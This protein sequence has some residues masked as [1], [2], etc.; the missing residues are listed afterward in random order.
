MAKK[1]YNIYRGELKTAGKTPTKREALIMKA[2]ENFGKMNSEIWRIRSFERRT[3]EKAN[4]LE[5]ELKAFGRM[6]GAKNITQFRAGTLTKLNMNQL[7]DIVARQERYLKHA[8][9]TGEGYERAY[10]Q[11]TKT[12]MEAYGFTEKQATDIQKLMSSTRVNDAIKNKLLDS[13]QVMRTVK[14]GNSV[15]NVVKFATDF[16]SAPESL[17]D[18]ISSLKG[19]EVSRIIQIT[20]SDGVGIAEAYDK[21][22]TE[23]AN[24]KH[25]VIKSKNGKITREWR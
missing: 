17:Q 22:A 20:A 13:D 19:S 1:K 11:R 5:L 3:G 12:F 10:K 25:L 9:A 18:K 2:G 15:D 23:K 8:Y 7:E 24:A 16:S 6:T 14:D 4:K 21:F